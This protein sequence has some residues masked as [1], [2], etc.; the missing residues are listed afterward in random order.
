METK[1]CSSCNI[2]QDVEKFYLREGKPR[3]QCKNCH[4]EKAKPHYL[5]NRER[6]NAYSRRWWKDNREKGKASARR[7]KYGITAEEWTNLLIS[8]EYKC[9]I[10]RKENNNKK[11]FHTDH[12]HNTGK[13]RGL[14]CSTCNT[15][16]G[17]L[18]DSVELLKLAIIYL[19][20]NK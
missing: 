5:A 17:G 12:D 16:I 2:E 19:E 20:K 11:D 8:Q 14:L 18:K 7:Q 4:S 15:G 1:I 10:C 9:A 3:S 6:Y 13:V